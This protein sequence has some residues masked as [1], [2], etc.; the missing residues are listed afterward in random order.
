M[1]FLWLFRGVFLLV[2]FVLQLSANLLLSF[3]GLG[4]V[5]FKFFLGVSQEV[6]CLSGDRVART[7]SEDEEEQEGHQTEDNGPK[8]SVVRR[9][10][11]RH[12]EELDLVFFLGHR[13]QIVICGLKVIFQ[14][15]DLRA[16]HLN[17]LFGIRQ[18][19][20]YGFQRIQHIPL[21]FLVGGFLYDFVLLV[22]AGFSIQ[23]VELAFQ[24]T[25]VQRGFRLLGS[26][27]LGKGREGNEYNKC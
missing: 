1:L 9:F 21:D 2:Q 7:E 25:S 10:C 3:E 4:L 15:R 8:Q 19:L 6:L 18:L 16:L 11:H 23:V 26:F 14:I 22:G 17:Q 20:F 24:S 27:V 13:R 5:G 12:A